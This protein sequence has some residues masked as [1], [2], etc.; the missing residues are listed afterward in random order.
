MEIMGALV[1]IAIFVGICFWLANQGFDG[2]SAT[3][4]AC[5]ILGIGAL[6]LMVFGIIKI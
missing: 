4:C 6:L 2:D 3:G 5:W 1:T